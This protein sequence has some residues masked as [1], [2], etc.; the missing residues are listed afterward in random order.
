MCRKQE[1][2]QLRSARAG[3][4]MDGSYRLR[5]CLPTIQVGS[6]PW[7]RFLLRILSLFPT[8]QKKQ[9]EKKQKKKKRWPSAQFDAAVWPDDTQWHM[10]LRSVTVCAE[11]LAAYTAAHRRASISSLAKTPKTILDP[12]PPPSS[13]SSHLANET[14]REQIQLNFRLAL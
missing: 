3:Q 14:L 1:R 4:D 8:A 6:P 7:L 5:T 13:S 12:S 2:Y 9:E 10:T 11:Q